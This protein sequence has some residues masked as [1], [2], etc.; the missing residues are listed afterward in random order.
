MKITI[1]WSDSFSL[2][3]TKCAMFSHCFLNQVLFFLKLFILI[4]GSL[5][6]NIVVVFAIHWRESAMGVHVFPILN[7][8]PTSL[9]IPSLRVIPVHLSTLSHASDLVRQSVSYMII[10]MFQCY[11]LKSSHPCLHPRIQKTVLYICV[12]FAI[13][14]IG[15][16]RYHLSKCHIHAL[17]Y[18]ISVSF[19][20]HS[21]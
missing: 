15:N 11:T 4:G 17:I 5:L 9:P 13:S 20:L 7:P 1:G 18:C 12:S 16:H 19:W 3:S 14:H 6:Y 8:P 21:V 2:L 10:Y